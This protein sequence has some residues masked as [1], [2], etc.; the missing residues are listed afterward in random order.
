MHPARCEYC[1]ELMREVP[2]PCPLLGAPKGIYYLKGGIKK[3]YA[4]KKK[5]NY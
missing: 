4:I 1:K 3:K 2:N 5:K